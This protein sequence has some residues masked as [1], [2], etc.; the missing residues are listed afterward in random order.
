M[1]MKMIE[2]DRRYISNNMSQGEVK[3]KRKKI[4][5]LFPTTGEESRH[6]KV[7]QETQK[8]DQLLIPQY[9]QQVL[10]SI[11]MYTLSKHS[12]AVPS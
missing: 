4:K 2:V 5:S 12:E 3:N 10:F 9:L 1:I 8:K 11:E 7:P 6:I